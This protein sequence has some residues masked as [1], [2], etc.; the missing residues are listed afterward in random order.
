MLAAT[1]GES[2]RSAT[3]FEPPLVTPQAMRDPVARA[4]T[5]ARVAG[6][7]RRRRAWAS[8]TALFDRLRADRAYQGIADDVLHDHVAAVLTRQADG[9]FELRCTP[10][11]EAAVYEAVAS[12]D[13]FERLDRLSAPAHFVASAPPSNWLSEVQPLA[14]AR[15]RGTWEGLAETSHFL[16]LERP[17][18]CAAIIRRQ[19]ALTA[20]CSLPA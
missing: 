2:W 17:E 1:D 20:D 6:A 18:A 13:P 7:R 10:E 11:T 5:E 19:V 15:A 3:L 4:G 9:S 14:A 12:T 8:P 16:P